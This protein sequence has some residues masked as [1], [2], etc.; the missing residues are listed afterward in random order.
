MGQARERHTGQLREFL[1]QEGSQVDELDAGRQQDDG[2]AV[3][4]EASAVLRNGDQHLPQ[5][6]G[7][8]LRGARDME[9]RRGL[10]TP[11]DSVDRDLRGGQA[12]DVV[13]VAGMEGGGQD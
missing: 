2:G 8:A 4:L 6:A 10:G 13:L 7:P 5:G 1:G 9:S 11:V 12:N 3:G